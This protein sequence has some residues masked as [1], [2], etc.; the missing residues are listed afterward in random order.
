[1]KRAG[2]LALVGLALLA[3]TSCDR[4][5]RFEPVTVTTSFGATLRGRPYA[6]DVLDATLRPTRE[7]FKV[8][9]I[10]GDQIV[11][12]FHS[13]RGPYVPHVSGDTVQF[14]GHT[15]EVLPAPNRYRVDGTVHTLAP[16]GIYLF[17]DGAYE[18]RWR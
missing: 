3:L 5:S 1:M 10:T 15:F 8:L 12:S 16:Q 2:P 11:I 13:S 14:G 17:S 9:Q 6:F 7:T 18:G 4:L